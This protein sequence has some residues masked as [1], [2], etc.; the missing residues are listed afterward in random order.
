MWIPHP[1]LASRCAKK[2]MLKSTSMEEVSVDE[3]TV[4]G[5]DLAKSVF[6]VH[7]ADASGRPVFRNVFCIPQIPGT[8]GRF[9]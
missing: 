8:D 6:Q 9:A 2:V 4:I 7:G 5:I 1:A 3:V